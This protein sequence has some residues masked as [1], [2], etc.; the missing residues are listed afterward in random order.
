MKANNVSFAEAVRAAQGQVAADWADALDGTASLNVFTASDGR[1]VGVMVLPGHL[2]PAVEALLTAR[3]GKPEE[4]RHPIEPA[5]EGTDE[6]LR[7]G[8]FHS[9]LTVEGHQVGMGPG[10]VALQL[11]WGGKK[12]PLL[13]LPLGELPGLIADLQSALADSRADPGAN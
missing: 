13:G 4:T 1:K 8:Q 2:V 10:V 6:P 5:R 3:H 12:Q 11:W 9:V 7:G